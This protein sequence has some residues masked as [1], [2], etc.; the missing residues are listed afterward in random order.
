MMS[1]PEYERFL[2]IAQRPLCM[3]AGIDWSGARVLVTGGTGCIG[4]A[5]MRELTRYKPERMISFSRDEPGYPRVPGAEYLWGDVRQAGTI[6]TVIGDLRPDIIFHTAAQRDPGLA[7][8]ETHRTVTTNVL[9]TRNLLQAA[10]EAQVPQV[11]LASTGKAL[12]P[13]SPDVYTASKRVAEWLGT[14]AAS[15]GLRVSAARFTHVIDN[16]LI[17]ERLRGWAAAGQKIQLH[18]ADIA[19]YVQS[20]IES[21]QLLLIAGHGAVDGEMRVHGIR[22]LGWPVALA[23]IAE[24]VLADLDSASEICVV[25]YERGYEEQAYPGL[26][27]PETAGGRSPLLSIFETAGPAYSPCPM[28]DS[29]SLQMGASFASL[30]W[31]RQLEDLCEHT[32]EAPLIRRALQDLSWA[33]LGDTLEFADPAALVRSEK[34]AKPFLDDLSD[35]HKRMF[36]AV[37]LAVAHHLPDPDYLL[38]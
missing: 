32:A 4:S 11:V 3:P 17:L 31:Q 22:N 25:G 29:F 26:Y 37:Q 10:G 12:R 14:L 13:Y 15:G 36:A 20:A 1:N 28:V 30:W 19:F 7:E 8:T 2:S 18:A 21:A 34:L 23:D 38:Q 9:G 6:A 16:S 33:L 27:D 24:G 35:D 5:L